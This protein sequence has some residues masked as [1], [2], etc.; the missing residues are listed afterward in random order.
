MLDE[1]PIIAAINGFA[2]GGGCELALSC[3]IRYA[4][5]NAIFGQPES[6][7]GLI[8]GFGGTQRLARIVGFGKALELLIR[9]NKINAKESY[10][11]GLIN[12]ISDGDVLNFAIEKA[13][14]IISCSP[15]SIS[16]ILACMLYGQKEGISKGLNMEIN[17]FSKL[18]STDNTNEGLSAFIQKRKP[19]YR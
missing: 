11:I 5:E 4:S 3:H 6:G 14:D 1:T 7:L 19:N 10:R 16:A 9:S 8:P 13:K 18:F 2:L 15:E 17:Q 12:E